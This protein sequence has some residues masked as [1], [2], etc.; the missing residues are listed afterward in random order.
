MKGLAHTHYIPLS[1]TDM[2]VSPNISILVTKITNVC[3]STVT[4]VVPCCWKSSLS[5]VCMYGDPLNPPTIIYYIWDVRVPPYTKESLTLT[6][7]Q[8]SKVGQLSS[9]CC[10]T[11]AK[12]KATSSG[13][14]LCLIIGLALEGVANTSKMAN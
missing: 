13:G 1:T 6:L 11:L 9:I 5:L 14:I 12:V 7:W 2:C 10:S 8:L 4:S 3:S